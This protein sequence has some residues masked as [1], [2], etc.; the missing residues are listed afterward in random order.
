MATFYIVRHGESEGN[1]KRNLGR[2]DQDHQDKG[3]DLTAL[4]EQQAKEF[5]DKVKHLHFAAIYS[6]DFLRAERT[7]KVVALERQLAVETTAVLRERSYGK[8]QKRAEEIKKEI[9]EAVKNL[10]DEE[11]LTYKHAPDIE[12]LDEVATR[13]LTFMR[14]LS[15]AYGGKNILIVSHGNAIRSLLMKLGYAKYDELPGGGKA[16]ANTGYVVVQSDGVDFFVKETHGITKK[17]VR[18]E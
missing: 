5:A 2:D 14:E 10:T 8:D 11:K 3:S 12:S 1:V 7:A 6:S 15:V 17:E 16:I 13:L 9:K 18:E 4:G